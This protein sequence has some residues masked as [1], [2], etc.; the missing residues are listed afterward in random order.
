MFVEKYL[1]WGVFCFLFVLFGFGFVFVL[2]WF[3]NCL[4]YQLNLIFKVLVS[5]KTGDNHCV[6]TIFMPLAV[7]QSYQMSHF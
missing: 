2:V 3:F 5:D 7:L 6:S 4:T 1:L